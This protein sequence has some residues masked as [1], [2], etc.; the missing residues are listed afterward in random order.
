MKTVLLCHG[1]D[2]LN[3]VALCRWLASFSQL[4]GIVVIEETRRRAVS[5]VK[6]E[7]KR[8][9]KIRFLDVLAYRVFHHLFLRSAEN[10]YKRRLLLEV[11]VKYPP[12]PE[13]LPSLVTASPNSPETQAFLE[14]VKPDLMVAR[15]KVILKPEIFQ[16]ARLGTYVMHPG[17]CP[18]YRNAHGCFW[19]LA[20]RDLGNVGMTL[21]KVDK[22]VDTGPV[23]GFFSYPYDELSES[24][25]VIQHRTVF[26][27][28]DEIRQKLV[29]IE[30]GIAIPVNVTGR[31]SRE[32]GQP[33][34][35]RY[36]A[37]KY[38]ARKRAK[39]YEADIA[40]LP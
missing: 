27:N 29:E 35:T 14:R 19:A 8:I 40:A 21:L 38:A 18:Q 16:I 17:I 32:W 24:H 10:A 9:G 7:M 3:R 39:G 5:R 1:G 23:Y 22:G 26:D 6:R 37:W 20:Q 33:W 2:D 30:R 15:C 13:D 4:S 28:L 34:L 36:L 25:T 12:I 31:S 11:S